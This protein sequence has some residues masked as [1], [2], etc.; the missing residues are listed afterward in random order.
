MK[1]ENSKMQNE[2]DSAIHALVVSKCCGA[3]GMCDWSEKMERKRL[4]L[5]SPWRI[6][7]GFCVFFQ[8]RTLRLWRP[9]G[10]ARGFWMFAERNAQY[11]LRPWDGDRGRESGIRGQES[12]DKGRRVKK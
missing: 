1:S 8:R 3:R 6:S 4:R 7:R 9:W 11:S 5:W 2:F 12:G 10:N